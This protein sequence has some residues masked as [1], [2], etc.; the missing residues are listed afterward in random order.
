M[1]YSNLL[2]VFLIQAVFVDRG[3]TQTETEEEEGDGNTYMEVI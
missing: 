2:K 1:K 3:F